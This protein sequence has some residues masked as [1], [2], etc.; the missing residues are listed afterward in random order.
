[1]AN[2]R[3]LHDWEMRA[4]R[5]VFAD[6]IEYRRVRVHE[7]AVWANVLDVWVRRLRSMRSR[8][9]QQQNSIALGFHCFFPVRLSHPPEQPR[10]M[11]LT[12]MAWLLHELTHVW[13][14]QL[15]GWRY[16]LLALV[17]HLRE[18]AQVYDFGGEADLRRCRRQGRKL[19][20][21]NLE[22]QAAIVQ[23]AYHLATAPQPDSI[24]REYLA[25]VR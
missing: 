7:G 22:Q 19:Q 20:S 9:A 21:F 23:T 11:P 12:S 6:C 8:P 5:T 16:L 15:I 24:W 18:G 17:A 14:F 2:S 13:Q 10:E 4:A 1:M 25:D 3:R